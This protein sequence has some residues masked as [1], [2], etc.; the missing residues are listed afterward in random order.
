MVTLDAPDSLPI[1]NYYQFG[2]NWVLPNV[3]SQF[4]E[5]LKVQCENGIKLWKNNGQTNPFKQDLIN[6]Y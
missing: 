5:Q 2:G 1:M 4:M 6:N 3:P